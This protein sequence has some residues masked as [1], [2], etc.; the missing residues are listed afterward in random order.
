MAAQYVKVLN[1]LKIDFTVV[2]RSKQSAIKF[3]SES[4]TERI[5]FSMDAALKQFLPGDSAIVAVSIPSL[6]PL[7]IQLLNA[8][9]KNLLLEK[10]AATNPDELEQLAVASKILGAKV[11]VGFNR[12][13]YSS[14]K[15][16]RE[17]ALI[18]GGISSFT[19]E[20]TEWPNV[21]E[22]LTLTA[23]EKQHWV[24]MNSFH[25]IDLAFHLGGYPQKI[26]C[27]RSEKLDWHDKGAIFAGSGRSE[28]GALFS[29][30]ADWGA[31]GRWSLEFCTPWNRY[32]LR[33]M[34]QLYVIHSGTLTSEEVTLDTADQ[35]F[36]PGLMRQLIAFLLGKDNQYL[37]GI[38][39]QV[40][41]IELCQK[42]TGY[43]T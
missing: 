14:V 27:L 21:I 16:L 18:E 7:A 10:P 8:G 1:A 26:E 40:K 37:C 17:Q 36:K 19:F 11:F 31:P 39:E 3:K 43:W 13:Y 24:W 29:Y 6:A 35:V 5:V 22:G 2:A 32:I 28:N 9:I 25:V 20:F 33:P 23:Y 12:R 30:K 4:A 34:E 38:D 42:M 15:Y 41:S